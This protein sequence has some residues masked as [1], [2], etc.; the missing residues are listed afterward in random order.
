MLQPIQFRVGFFVSCKIH[1]F[2]LL[3]GYMSNQIAVNWFGFYP[4]EYW[5]HEK[6]SSDSNVREYTAEISKIIF[7]AENSS[8]RLRVCQD[9]LIL[10]N[11]KNTLK[12]S[13]IVEY[14]NCFMVLLE[15]HVSNQ[16]LEKFFTI[17]EVKL[18]D[19]IVQEYTGDRLTKSGM[20]GVNERAKNIYSQ[21]YLSYFMK[22]DFTKVDLSPNSFWNNLINSNIHHSILTKKRNSKI[23]PLEVFDLVIRDFDRVAT[24]TTLIKVIASLTRAIED[25]RESNYGEALVFTWFI[26]E[27]YLFKL[28]ETKVM[29]G[30]YDEDDD[31]K[32]VAMLIRELKQKK[33]IPYEVGN[34]LHSIRLARNEVVHNTFD[35]AARPEDTLL[36]I[37]AIRQFILRDT[38]INLNIQL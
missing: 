3:S 30:F 35:A 8:F 37:E 18:S 21:R 34:D 14:M 36:S 11:F 1:F 2:R 9:G 23:L 6:M 38:G 12:A 16:T 7:E 15:S 31:T 25:F 20:E 33:I 26:I 24:D 29:G 5:P 17:N 27:A 28:Y 22:I 13:A 10:F 19:I 32:S 4:G